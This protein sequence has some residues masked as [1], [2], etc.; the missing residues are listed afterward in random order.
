MAIV[1]RRTQH[2]KLSAKMLTPLNG[3]KLD[4]KK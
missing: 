3:L 1:N 4:G 2:L